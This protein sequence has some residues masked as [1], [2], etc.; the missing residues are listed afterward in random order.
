[1]V[2]KRS[3]SNS[4]FR[5]AS[6]LCSLLLFLLACWLYIA[7]RNTEMVLFNWLG[8][9]YN[10]YLFQLL[11]IT[12]YQP[13]SWLIY[14]LPD[15]LWML[16]FLLLMECIWGNDKLKWV[17]ICGMIIFAY[18]L[19]R[20]QYLHACPGTGDIWDFVCYTITI[21]LYLSIHKLKFIFN[22]KVF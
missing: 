6:G 1:M 16:S 7:F 5:I 10:N 20:L 11:R 22:E 2:I 9:D 17:F 12:N 4:R 13:A 8:I 14:N 18:V 19:E 15:G 3:T 21:L